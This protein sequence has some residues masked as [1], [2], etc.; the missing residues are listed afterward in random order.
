MGLFYIFPFLH[1]ICNRNFLLTYRTKEAFAGPLSV[2]IVYGD[3][4]TLLKKKSYKQGSEWREMTV[5][6]GRRVQ[7]FTLRLKVQ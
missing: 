2:F 1:K 4:L 3:R 6:I 5:D 7:P